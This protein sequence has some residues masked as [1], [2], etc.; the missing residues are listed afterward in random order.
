MISNEAF[1][2]RDDK[3]QRTAVSRTKVSPGREDV[4]HRHPGQRCPLGHCRALES[5]CRNHET[6]REASRKKITEFRKSPD[7][8]DCIILSGFD[9]EHEGF[10][11]SNVG[12][13]L[14]VA[15]PRWYILS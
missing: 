8:L 10:D 11:M 15:C 13:V 7:L 14:R 9:R 12:D 1:E 2:P 3:S 5:E 4:D 6:G